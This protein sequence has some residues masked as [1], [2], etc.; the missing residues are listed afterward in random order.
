MLNKEKYRL[1]ISKSKLLEEIIYC[2]RKFCKLMPEFFGF[3]ADY[4]F[5]IKI[6]LDEKKNNFFEFEHKPCTIFINPNKLSSFQEALFTTAHE[7]GHY[8]H[9]LKKPEFYESLTQVNLKDKSM[10]ERLRKINTITPVRE[11]IA[12]LASFEFFRL[13]D[14][15]DRFLTKE[16]QLALE[17]LKLFGEKAVYVVASDLLVHYYISKKNYNEGRLLEITTSDCSDLAFFKR[18]N[19]MFDEG[20]KY[21]TKPSNIINLSSPYHQEEPTFFGQ[22]LQF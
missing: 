19:L 10:I 2:H 7:S 13:E 4:S 3:S 22:Q 12:D 8:L 21:L 20:R 15:L 16:K 18:I 17:R 14:L 9:Y 11:L 1:F 5:P 6:F